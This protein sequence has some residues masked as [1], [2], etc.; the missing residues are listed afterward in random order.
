MKPLERDV[1]TLRRVPLFAGLSTAALKLLAYTAEIVHFQ[2]GE[3]IARAGEQRRA[4]DLVVEGDIEVWLDQP[5]ARSVRLWTMG[6]PSLVGETAVLCRAAPATTVRAKGPVVTFRIASDV[7]VAL[8]QDHAEMR[9][10]V[11]KKLAQQLESASFMLG[12]GG[13]LK[14]PVQSSAV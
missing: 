3:V 5:G 2:P 6:P 14:A 12:H 4:I 13:S 11:M 8:L 1:E 9:F 7:F 10:H